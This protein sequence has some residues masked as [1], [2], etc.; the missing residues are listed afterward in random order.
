MIQIL[1]VLLNALSN[2]FVRGAL[3]EQFTDKRFPVKI[4]HPILF[5]LTAYVGFTN[6]TYAILM[7]IACRAGQAPAIFKEV[8]DTY[9]KDKKHIRW[10]ILVWLR[11]VIWILPMVCVSF[12]FN[13]PA[14]F[15]F[16]IPALLMPVC[17]LGVWKPW[18]NDKLNHWT[19]AEFVFGALIG[20]ALVLSQQF[21][22]FIPSYSVCE[23]LFLQECLRDFF[24]YSIWCH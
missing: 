20:L 14:N 19:E 2:V 21:S 7:A 8:G 13:G 6:V 5:G 17:Y 9:I 4:L 3:Y 22:Q 11:G 24:L 1:I 12:I 10:L 16:V 18:G 23:F 15:F